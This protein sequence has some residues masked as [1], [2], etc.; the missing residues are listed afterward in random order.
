MN[1][2]LCIAFAGC[3]VALGAFVLA[4]RAQS[5]ADKQ[6]LRQMELQAET[7]NHLCAAA[8]PEAWLTIQTGKMRDE[9]LA[10]ED[11]LLALEG[12]AEESDDDGPRGVF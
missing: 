8:N 12:E 1:W 5:L 6:A 3:V 9:R 4:W 7:L 10:K 2:Y 11:A